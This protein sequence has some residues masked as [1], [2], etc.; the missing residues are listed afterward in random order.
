MSNIAFTNCSIFDGVQSFIQPDMT[1]LIENGKITEI[2]KSENLKNLS[3][4]ECIDLKGKY[5]IP[6]LINAH[7]HLPLSGNKSK[8]TAAGDAQNLLLKLINTKIGRSVVLNM[9]KHNAFTELNSGVTTC[10]SLGD[11]FYQD[12]KLRDMIKNGKIIGPRLLVAGPIITP[13]G[14]HG[15]ALGINADSPWEFRKVVRKNIKQQ[16]DVIKIANTG[17]VADA[18]KI[19]EAGRPTMTLEE[20]SAACDEAHK[21]GLMVSSHS[22]SKEGVKLALKAGVDTIEHG[23]SLDDEMI[24]LFLHNPNSLRGYSCLI[25]TVQ[26]AIA[27]AKIDSSMTYMTDINIANAKFVNNEIVKGIQ[28]ATKEGIKV[29][30]GTDASMPF[31]T[32]YNTWRELEFEIKSA[33]LTTIQALTNATRVNAEILGIDDCTGTLEKG[34]SSDLIVLNSNPLKDIRTLSNISMV[35]IGDHFIRKPQV[36]RFPEVDAALDSIVE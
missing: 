33:G 26:P 14:G 25:P 17:G 22:E 32:H 34:K 3:N 30:L 18:R 36:K 15:E 11:L 13:T 19:G 8:A 16:V 20:I 27:I 35:M 1:I 29:G 4:Y 12:I 10:R 2:S 9:M 28:I 23:A 24:D 21:A 5:I 7:I 31:V 6:G